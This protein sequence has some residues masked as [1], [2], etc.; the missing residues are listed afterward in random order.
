MNVSRERSQGYVGEKYL[1]L[2][3]VGMDKKYNTSRTFTI[4]FVNL[5]FYA[6]PHDLCALYHFPFFVNRS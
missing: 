6:V 2:R 4:R 3:T 1:F 5:L